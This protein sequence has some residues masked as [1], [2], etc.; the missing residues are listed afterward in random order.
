MKLAWTRFWA[1]VSLLCVPLAPTLAAGAQNS[2]DRTAKRFDELTLAGLRP[3]V[4]TEAKAIRLYKGYRRQGSDL[5]WLAVCAKEILAIEV[6]EDHKIQT[7]RAT[8]ARWIPG[9]CDK[10]GPTPWRTGR[11]LRI[12]SP[13]SRAI[14]LYGEPDSRSPS[15]KAGQR[16]ELL[17]YAFDWAGPDVPQVMEVECTVGKEGEPGRVVEITLAASSL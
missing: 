3:E 5:T 11:G 8:E 9:D 7:V 14:E 1:S 10:Y 12:G 15:T 6:D 13:A 4:D 2:K 17:Y 16:L